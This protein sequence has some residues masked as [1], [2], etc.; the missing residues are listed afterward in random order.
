MKFLEIKDGVIINL[1]EIRDVALNI[2][3]V[4][5]SWVDIG[6]TNQAEIIVSYKGVEKETR[7]RFYGERMAAECREAY[8]ILVAELG[9]RN[10]ATK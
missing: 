5:E 6:L 7:I 3:N 8:D 9:R 2:T 10:D 4:P 1:D